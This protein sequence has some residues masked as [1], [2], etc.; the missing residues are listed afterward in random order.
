MPLMS[1]TPDP[2]SRSTP[3]RSPVAKP[4][5]PKP[6]PKAPE[7]PPMPKKSAAPSGGVPAIQINVAGSAKAPAKPVAPR[8]GGKKASPLPLILTI[9]AVLLLV[10]GAGGFAA[11]VALSDSFGQHETA[12]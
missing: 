11:Y 5:M 2:R 7:L 12:Q 10:G 8:R 3:G 6:A 4:P 9:A 1:K